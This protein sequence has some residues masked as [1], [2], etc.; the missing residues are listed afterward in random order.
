M[1]P[2]FAL[3]IVVVADPELPVQNDLFIFLEIFRGLREGHLRR[4]LLPHEVP[5]S[6]PIDAEGR[7]GV[8]ERDGGGWTSTFGP[9]RFGKPCRSR[10]PR[11]S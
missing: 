2:F 1:D 8:G 6:L 4:I 11:A 10:K 7:G 9:L 3:E 5:V